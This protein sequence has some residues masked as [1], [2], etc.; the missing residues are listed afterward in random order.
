MA[1]IKIKCDDLDIQF[2]V[3]PTQ[4]I[5]NCLVQALV[6]ALP[7]ALDAFFKCIADD[8]PTDDNYKPGDRQRCD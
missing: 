3:T 7:T 6:A 5:I 8:G 2:E 1:T 4:T